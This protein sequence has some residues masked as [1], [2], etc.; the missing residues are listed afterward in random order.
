MV[1]QRQ[2]R[3]GEVVRNDIDRAGVARSVVDDAESVGGCW[4]PPHPL[5]IGLLVALLLAL[6]AIVFAVALLT[7]PVSSNPLQRHRPPQTTASVA[8]DRGGYSPAHTTAAVRRSAPAATG[9]LTATVVSD[10][11]SAATPTTAPTTPTTAPAT[12]TPTTSSSPT[13]AN[14]T[15]APATISDPSANIAPDP[16][17]LASGPCTGTAGAQTCANPCATSSATFTVMDGDPACDAYVLQAIDAA[18]ADEGLAPMVLPSNWT[19][20]STGEQLFVVANLERTAR[21]LAPYLGINAALSAEAQRAASAGTD[22]GTAAGFA[23]GVDAQGYVAYGGA[24]AGGFSVLAADYVWMYDDGWGGSQAATPN[25][26]CTSAASVGCWAHRDE[27]LGYDP[28]YNP[29]VGLDCADCEFGVGYA[30]LGSSGSYADL[31]E[32]PVGA[33]PAMTFTWSEELAQAN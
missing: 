13:S 29:G 26:E 20:L 15:S 24:W 18:R 5:L 14:D 25:L 9:G 16:D 23:V 8:H 33:P 28:R 11:T 27:L 30:A 1:T 17:F 22:P 7:G 31:V 19:S 21:G 32:L 6:G 12:S 4:Q 10:T 2:T 3:N